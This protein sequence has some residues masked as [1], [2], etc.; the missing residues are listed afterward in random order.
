[1]AGMKLLVL[2]WFL[3]AVFPTTTNYTLNSY[4]FG[5]GGTAN[6]VTSNYALEGITGEV[7]GQNSATST[8]TAKPGFNE[9]QQANLPKILSFNNNSGVYYNK[10]HFVIDEQ[11]NPSDA[12]YAMSIS[13][14]NFSS[15]IRY[16]KSDLTVGSSLTLSDYQDYATW[17]G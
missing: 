14:D 10:L 5:N 2:G 15:D 7:G 16:V 12:L 8:Y 1:M 17:G 13:T 3:F 9:T 6:S 11:G 4:G